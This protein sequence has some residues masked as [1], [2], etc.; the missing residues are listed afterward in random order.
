MGLTRSA[1]VWT[2][3]IKHSDPELPDNLFQGIPA[4]RFFFPPY[5]LG[6]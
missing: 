4:A 6:K 1:S 3:E 2:A 5:I